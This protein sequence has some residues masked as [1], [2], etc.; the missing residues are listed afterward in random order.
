LEVFYDFV[1]RLIKGFEK[2]CVDYAFTGALAVSFYSVP[3]TT[4]DVDVIVY[5]SEGKQKTK[6]VDALREAGLVVDEAEIDSALKSGYR[7]VTFRDCKT[8]YLVDV[9]ISDKKFERKRG[10]IAGLTAFFQKPEDLISAK[11]RM[12]RATVPRE[13]AQ[14]DVEDVKAMLKFTKVNLKAVRQQAEKEGT[15]Q[16]LEGIIAQQ[17]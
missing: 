3:R 13:R 15:I 9:I 4:V 5:V 17:N 16:I 7:I 14:K 12:I 2:A 6:L 1:K 8:P 10:K 11:L